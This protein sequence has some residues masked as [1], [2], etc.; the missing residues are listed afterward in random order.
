MSAFAPETDVLGTTAARPPSHD[1]VQLG[2][3]ARSMSSDAV[4]PPHPIDAA[5][6]APRQRIGV[7][8]HTARIGDRPWTS[9]RVRAICALLL[10]NV[11]G[12]STF[13]VTKPLLEHIPPLTIATARFAIGLLVL[14]PLLARSGVRPARGR[15][16][17]MMGFTG[18]FLVYVLQNLGLQYT[19]ATNAA[20]LEGSTPIF[21]LLLAAPLIGEALD[22]RRFVGVMTSLAGVVAIVEVGGHADVNVSAFGDSLVTLSS[23]GFAAYLI[24][25]RRTFASGDSLALVAGVACYG[26]LF[27]LSA[28]AIELAVVGLPRP[29]AMDLLGLLFLGGVASAL[30][31]VLWGYGLRHLE[32]GQAACFNNLCPLVG[33]MFAAVFLNESINAAQIAGGLLIL[34]GVYLATRLP[35]SPLA[36]SVEARSVRA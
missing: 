9:P 5:G 16:V 36:A 19:S 21:T 30:A 25:G 11:L 33:V 22:L 14:L 1:A 32:A 26:L 12:G 24:L 23:L 27:L 6:R 3:V 18:V 15:S 34:G 13:V 4:S 2:L 29:T 8:R 31:Y 28:T 35:R 20:I 10:V 7:I 17:A